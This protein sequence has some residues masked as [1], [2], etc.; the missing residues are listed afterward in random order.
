[1]TRLQKK[2]TAPCPRCHKPKTWV[3]EMCAAC[4]TAQRQQEQRNRL[5]E[6]R[7]EQAR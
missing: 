7:K 6:R 4:R 2:K 1:M 5:G 3:A